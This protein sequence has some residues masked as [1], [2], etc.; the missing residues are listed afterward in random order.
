LNIAMNRPARA[1]TCLVTL[2]MI[3]ANGVVQAD[4]DLGALH[5]AAKNGNATAQHELGLRY[6][7][8]NGIAQNT[9]LGV[10]WIERAAIQGYVHAQ[11]DIGAFFHAGKGLPQDF[12]KAAVYYSLAAKQGHGF[13]ALNIGGLYMNGQGV[14]QDSAEA[15][16]WFT[17][18]SQ[19]D[20]P[21]AATQGKIWSERL[22]E[23]ARRILERQEEQERNRAQQT[24]SEFEKGAAAAAVFMAVT[25]ALFGGDNGAPASASPGQKW[26][27]YDI[28]SGWGQTLPAC[29]G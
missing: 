23:R 8:G 17:R 6:Y 22:Q 10:K 13:A 24:R 18:A 25:L 9:D 29:G 5:A 28:C 1:I 14:K 27:P 19:S 15:A 2:L 16:Y 26:E 12:R 7:R 4:E 3:A 20:D 11:N 21:K